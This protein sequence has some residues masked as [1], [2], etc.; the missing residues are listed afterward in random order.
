MLRRVRREVRLHT[1]Y[2]LRLARENGYT[3]VLGNAYPYDPL[4]PPVWYM[5]W[6]VVKNLIPGSIVILHDGRPDPTGSLEALPA[7]LAAGQKRGLR[8]VSVGSL[9]EVAANP[10][11]LLNISS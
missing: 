8:F 7:I 9:L 10:S 5:E 6:L 1:E 4:R 2:G 3:C 11:N